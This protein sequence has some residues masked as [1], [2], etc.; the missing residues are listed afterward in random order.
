[1]KYSVE[2]I[3]SD[4]N[5]LQKLPVNRE[6]RD[7]RT[8]AD[9]VLV[10]ADTS[11]ID[12][13]RANTILPRIVQAM[14]VAGFV[15]P[16]AAI[17]QVTLN[18]V[19]A[20]IDQVA[21]A[22]GVATGQTI[23]VDPRVKGQLNLVSEQPVAEGKAIKTLE[24]A[25]RMQGYALLQ[26]HGVLK[27]VPEAD[28]KLQG[29]PTYFGNTPV[30]EGDQVITQIFQ[31][32]YESANSLLSVL[33]PLISPNNAIAAY[34]TNNTLVVTDYADNV[35]RIAS[36]IAGI[37][38]ASGQA[39]DI[40]LL[41]N[42]NA[43]DLAPEVTRIL[44]PSTVGGTD[45][46]LKIS[47]LPDARTN[48]LVIR[49]SST[50]RLQEA[51]A[52]IGK[53]DTPSLEP[54]NIHVVPLRNAD[55]RE[56]SKTLR[57]MMGQ[58]TG[59]D[60]SSSSQN[61]FDQNNGEL[62]GKSGSGMGGSS[63]NQGVVPPLPGNFNVSGGSSGTGIASGSSN[64]F[65]SGEAKDSGES[66]SHGGMIIQPDIATN[67]LVIT[68]SEPVYRNLRNV[69]DQ[70]DA[71]RPQVYIESLIVELNS[72][73][74]MQLGVQWQGLLSQGGNTSLYGSSNFATATSNGI[75]NLT[76]AGYAANGATSSLA[77]ASALLNN[78]LNIGLL[79][80]FGKY[81]GLGGLLQALQT[82]GDVNVLSTPNLMMLDNEDAKIVVGQNV[83]FV[84]GS[85]AQTGSS[86]SVTPFQTYDRQ[87]VGITLHVRPQITAGGTIKLQ[88]YTE[89]SSVVNGT[90][91]SLSGPTVN[92]RSIQSSVLAD[93]G[94]IVVLGGLIQDQYTNDNSKVPWLGSLPVVGAL[95]RTEDKDRTKT[96]LMVFI[97][98]VIIR[99]SDTE[100]GISM[101]RY[102]YIRGE[103]TGYVSDNRTVRDEQ[104]PVVPPAPASGAG[105]NGAGALAPT[106]QHITTQ[107]RPATLQ[108]QPAASPRAAPVFGGTQQ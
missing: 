47:V 78:G 24:S 50:A 16:H 106:E 74:A 62:G 44:E 1:M 42:A 22:I 79:H 4:N 11:P 3:E 68:A 87:D 69:I 96:D 55:A 57:G 83:P 23:V 76:A 95:F 90:A 80:Q 2:L 19:N 27:V 75:V 10:Q 45:P 94:S 72:D 52:L 104:G 67:S 39:A 5:I 93:D 29:V 15:L 84:T 71:R 30:A 6:H 108:I 101:N 97:R 99:D 98:P 73:K 105:A 91:N 13:T 63:S 49:A 100:Q 53:L 40:V 17:A 37:D 9:G 38:V 28:A 41:K 85:Y 81:L 46:T 36:I 86:T 56:L 89:S 48:S 34:P 43:L 103:T 102:N 59:N 12:I 31:L 20:D 70:L 33:R 92:K 18:F 8:R 25:L 58:S 88:I 60:S 14:L 61:N 107:Q 32:R 65:G 51:K 35:R 64:S 54:G 66:G 26:D 77:A 7:T 82:S 21:K